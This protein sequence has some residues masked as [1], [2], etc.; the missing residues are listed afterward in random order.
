LYNNLAKLKAIKTQNI[1][2]SADFDNERNEP[3]FRWKIWQIFEKTF[4]NAYLRV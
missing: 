3:N 4:K 2:I 1:H